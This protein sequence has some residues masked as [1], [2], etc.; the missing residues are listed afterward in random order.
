MLDYR[1]KIKNLN[2]IYC[3]SNIS[4]PLVFLFV[5]FL[6]V[7]C[8]GGG[9]NEAANNSYGAGNY[10]YCPDVQPKNGGRGGVES[11]PFFP[12]FDSS[13]ATLTHTI[14]KISYIY[15]TDDEVKTLKKRLN[16]YTYVAFGNFYEK[17][18]VEPGMHAKVVFGRVGDEYALELSLYGNGGFVPSADKFQEIFGDVKSAISFFYAWRN[19][20][21]DMKVRFKNYISLADESGFGCNAIN[22]GADTPKRWFNAYGSKTIDW[23]IDYR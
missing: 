15:I 18:N 17:C 6:F 2:L 10:V 4:K 19:Y 11:Y 21:T 3:I 22:C 9:S 14:G 7:G 20:E 5:L 8:S 12:T 1:A 16:G 23:H 13:G